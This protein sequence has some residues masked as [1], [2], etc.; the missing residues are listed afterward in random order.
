MNNIH[1]LFR[2]AMAPFAPLPQV[3]QPF[4]VT[5]RMGQKTETINVL[6]FT[7]CDAICTAIDIYFDGEEAMPTEGL[8]IEARPMNL[9]P[10]AA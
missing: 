7:T 4:A 2:N 9:L 5:L 10:S 3:T 8:S 1:P 6:A